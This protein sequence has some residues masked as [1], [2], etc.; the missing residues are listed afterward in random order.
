MTHSSPMPKQYSLSSVKIS[1]EAIFESSYDGIWITDGKGHVLYANEAWE[2]ITGI[3]RDEVI[4]KT[5]EELLEKKLFSESVTLSVIESKKR[6]T[7]M[8]FNY[9][10]QKHA[11][12]TGNP[13]FGKNGSVEYIIN[14]VRDITDLTRLKEKLDK[15][16][17]LINLQKTELCKLRSKLSLSKEIVFSSQKMNQLV[18]LAIRVAGFDCTVLIQGESGAGKGVIAKAIAEN[19]PRKD[20]PFV[21][22]DCGSIPPNLLESELFGYE[23]GAFTGADNKGKKG[24]FELADKGTVFLDEIGELPQS[25]QVKLLH[26]LQEREIKRVGG[27]QQIPLDIRI[28]AATN[29]NLEE[30]VPRGEF[31]E[32]LFFRLNVVT[33]TLPPLRE[34][35]EDIPLLCNHFLKHFN[36]K[37]AQDKS[38]STEAINLL[39]DYS[40]PGN[41]RELQNLIENLVI[42]IPDQLIG[43]EHL[44]AKLRRESGAA[45]SQIQING[46]V[47]L[48]HAVRTLEET[49]IEKAMQKYKTT[50]K[51]AAALGINQSTLVKKYQTLGMNFDYLHDREKQE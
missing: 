19:S 47:P 25:L 16:D 23:K 22:I 40:W 13:V 48:K 32:D 26:T 44:P 27:T 8:V 33:L 10:T 49:L 29:K 45:D 3:S 37:H 51:A 11:L 14:N 4:G 12:T 17:Q 42:I 15:K 41:I 18:D 9:K 31:R 50:R 5:T 39:T 24:L 30:M 38:L 36:Q 7:M 28:I 34:R 2:R 43:L 21:Q 6:V 46:I 1:S 35:A 20:Y